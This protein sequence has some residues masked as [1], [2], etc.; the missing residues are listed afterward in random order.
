MWPPEEMREKRKIEYSV[1]N[2]RSRRCK[3]VEE[4][5]QINLIY[6]LQ[7]LHSFSVPAYV[8]CIA[9]LRTSNSLFHTRTHSNA[10][11][12][13]HLLVQKLAINKN[14]VFVLIHFFSVTKKDIRLFSSTLFCVVFRTFYYTFCVV[15]FKQHHF[16]VIFA[17]SISYTLIFNFNFNFN[18]NQYWILKTKE[19]LLHVL[20]SFCIW[21]KQNNSNGR[22]A[23][24]LIKKN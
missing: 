18:S 9:I 21:C 11:S 10:R 6:D 20:N 24:I 2:T 3:N 5:R 13:P 1:F 19:N 16:C 8:L 4:K 23:R 15:F 14:T 7:Q 17:I 12:I 22:H